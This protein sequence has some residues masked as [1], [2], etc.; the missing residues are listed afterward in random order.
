MSRARKGGLVDGIRRKVKTVRGRRAGFETM[1]YGTD[2][3]IIAGDGRSGIGTRQGQRAPRRHEGT[4]GY[5]SRAD[6]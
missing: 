4:V 2:Y 6:R 1:G 3:D 5:G